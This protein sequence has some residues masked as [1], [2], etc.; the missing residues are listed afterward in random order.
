M[1]RDASSN[2]FVVGNKIKNAGPNAANDGITISDSVSKAAITN[3]SI[4]NNSGIGID[5]DNNGITLND[6]GDLDSGPNDL[7]NYP[8]W[9]NI[10]ESSGDTIVDF[11]ADLPVG[12]YRI[13]FFSNTALG[14]NSYPQGETYLGYTN[15][16]STGEIANFNHILSGITG[17]NFLSLT[18]TEIDGSSP[19]GF[20]ATSEFGYEGEPYIPIPS[21]SIA[22][23]LDNPEDFVQGGSVNY[24]ITVVND[25]DT[26]IDLTQYDGGDFSNPIGTSLFTDFLPEGMSLVSVV[27]GPVSCIEA[28]SLYDQAPQLFFNHIGYSGLFCVYTGGDTEFEP[29]ESVAITIEVEIDELS[30]LNYTNYATPGWTDFE[31]TG[32]QI[33][34]ECLGGEGITESQ[35]TIDCLLARRP[36]GA[37]I[38]FAGA[39]TDI[40]ITKT[41]DTPN[42]ADPGDEVSYELRL[43]NNGP[44]DVNLAWYANLNASEVVFIDAFPAGLSFVDSDSEDNIGCIDI[45]P[46]TAS[47]LPLPHSNQDGNI[48]VCGYFGGDSRILASGE[49]VSVRI[50]AVVNNGTTDFTNYAFHTATPSDVDTPAIQSIESYEGYDWENNIF[51]NFARAIYSSQGNGGPE[52]EDPVPTPGGQSN[53]SGGGGPNEGDLASTGEMM[54]LI[55]LLGLSAISI[56][57]MLKLK[58]R[59]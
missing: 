16:T 54:W 30:G 27:N 18:A 47:F 7:L 21:L 44:G 36:V 28:G 52:P 19:S 22:K 25:G 8:E 59:G 55:L 23:T 45:G 48:V 1:I 33:A 37:D 42:G 38:A 50:N 29:E 39:P 26:T 4:F 40:S 17:V 12:E 15:I 32:T 6:E 46:G 14:S 9:W 10:E 41:L 2:I 31:D 11:V 20:G 58:K 3:N 34:G 51:N 5:L 49:S 56:A 53:G 35:D 43:T 13:E 57:V 24:T